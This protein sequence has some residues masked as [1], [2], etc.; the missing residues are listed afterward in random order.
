MRESQSRPADVLVSI[1]VAVADAALAALRAG[2]SHERLETGER[3]QWP[4]S[5]PD[6]PGTPILHIGRFARGLG[7]FTPIE[8][9]PPAELPDDEYPVASIITKLRW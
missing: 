6:K 9:V 1:I 5:G 3:L 4:V 8:H 2:I 7:K